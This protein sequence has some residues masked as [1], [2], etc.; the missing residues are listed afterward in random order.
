M[1]QELQDETALDATEEYKMAQLTAPPA[2]NNPV[3][4]CWNIIVIW[5]ISAT[6]SIATFRLIYKGIKWLLS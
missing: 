5:L 1:N 6:L 3:R 2:A 4:V